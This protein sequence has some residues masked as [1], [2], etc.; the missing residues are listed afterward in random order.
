[1][2]LNIIYHNNPYNISRYQKFMA[3]NRLD[4]ILLERLNTLVERFIAHEARQISIDS[5]KHKKVSHG[6]GKGYSIRDEDNKENIIRFFK[7]AGYKQPDTEL[8]KDLSLKY[9]NEMVKIATANPSYKE[10][11][12]RILAGEYDF[13]SALEISACS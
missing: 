2:F 1:M 4:E 10:L 13:L 3:N 9:L 7:D 5:G 8:L 12:R 6:F 11:K